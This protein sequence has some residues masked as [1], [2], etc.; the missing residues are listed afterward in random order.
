MLFFSSREE[1]AREEKEGDRE[2]RSE[3]M[4]KKNEKGKNKER[5][6]IRCKSFS[7]LIYVCHL[8]YLFRNKKERKASNSS[9]KIEN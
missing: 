5:S 1:N 4:E 3:I 9:M 6:G 2:R 8:I 7:T